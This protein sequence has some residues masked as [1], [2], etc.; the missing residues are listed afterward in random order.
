M[1]GSNR[2]GFGTKLGGVL[3]AAGSAVGLGNIWRF[4]TEA[5]LNGGGAFILVYIGCVILFGLPL[6]M[7]EFMIGRHAR[8][9]VGSA[10]R[11]LAPN[12][13]WRFLGPFTVLIAFLI[14]SYYN[15]VAGWVFYYL[16]EAATGSFV[17]LSEAVSSGNAN[18]FADN[19]TSFVSDPVKPVICLLVTIGITHFVV[20]RGV[21]NGIERSSKILMPLLFLIILVLI[22]FALRMPGASKGLSFIFSPDFSKIDGKVVLAALSQCFYSLS[23]GMGLV[24][25]ASYFHREANLGRSALSVAFMDTMV[26]IAAGVIIF[27][28]VFSVAGVEPTAGASLVFISLPSVFDSALSD[29][30]FLMWLIPVMFFALL[31][32]ATLTSTIFLHEVVTAW[33][34]ETFGLTRH[35][36]ARIITVLI[37]LLGIC[38]SLSMGPWSGFK[39]SGMNLFDLFDDVTTKYMLPISGL[40]VAIFAGWKLTT[41][42]KWVELTSH[43][44]IKFKFLSP[45]MIMLR[46]ICPVLLVVIM[47]A[48]IFFA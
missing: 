30:P 12:S 34:S 3:A 18:A 35:R 14:L 1:S 42:Q 44:L 19:F 36:S 9:N 27:P 29:A 40:L 33:A 32:F 24:T 7:A 41:R 28:A 20:T 8:A 48:G 23:L 16:F 26:A 6:M 38:C 21:R 13:S 10:Y 22:V 15:V 47:V 2:I 17:T 11:I 31:I 45:L 37:I 4:P 5:G 46:Y 43:G 25:Y 39:I